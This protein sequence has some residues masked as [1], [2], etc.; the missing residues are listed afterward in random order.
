MSG[1]WH[2][3]VRRE[4][5]GLDAR[6]ELPV[7]PLGGARVVGLGLAAF[8]GLFVWSPAR[9][10]WRTLRSWAETGSLGEQ[11]GLGL[12]HIPFV[13]V[14]VI[15]LVLGLLVLFGRCRVEWKEGR[16]RSAEVLGPFWWTRRLP[17][18]PLR[19]LAVVAAPSG[20]GQAPPRGLRGLAGLFAE[21]EG[22]ARKIV[23]LAYPRDWL[24][25]LARELEALAGARGLV[26]APVE[27][28]LVERWTPEDEAETDVSEQ[29]GD[30][31]VRLE[32]WSSGLRLTVPPAGL[33]RGSKGLFFFALVWCAFMTVFT[34]GVAVGSFDGEGPAWVPVV[35]I[36][37]FWAFGLGLLAVAVNMGRR[38]AVI[39]VE[40]GRL[41]VEVRGLFGG[42]RRE[43][44]AGELL[45]VRADSGFEVNDR[46]VLELQ[47]HPAEGKR[48]GMLAGRDD[49]ELRWMATRL[50]EA[51]GLPGRVGR[52]ARPERR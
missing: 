9:D 46:P 12:F 11:G 2:T 23:A 28:E 27:V 24:L 1:S 35:F 49:D 40:G 50:R 29:P 38:T 43:W 26:G 16:L 4:Y 33:W 19:R 3:A 21:Y 36:S 10:L 51:L 42:T 45:A 22:G 25:A 41:L 44:D 6:F 34:V 39:T 18:Q 8:S 31:Q 7:R 47:V 48:W 17:R 13:L 14:G 5:A 15:P 32:E 20:E 37:V 30:S 52:H